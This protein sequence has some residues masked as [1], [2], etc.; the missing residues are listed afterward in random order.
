VLFHYVVVRADLPRG[1]LAAQIVHAAGESSP[2][3]L[4]EGTN[5]VV[6]AVKDEASLVKL[7][8]KLDAQRIRFIRIVEPD[9]PWNGALMALGFPPCEERRKHLS[10]VQLLK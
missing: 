5:A 1:I 7:A 6:L 2:G 9:A 8:N 4:P 10:S 3:G